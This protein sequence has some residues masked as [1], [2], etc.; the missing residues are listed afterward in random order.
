MS[1][2]RDPLDSLAEEFV[3]R[4]R[5]GERLT[6]S[7]YALDHPEFA[8][9]IRDLFP[10]LV[11]MENLKDPAIAVTERPN[12]MPTAAPERVGDCRI[13]REIGR[14]GMGVVY[15][16]VQE[17][18]ARR[19]AVKVLPRGLI[20]NDKQLHRF[21]R[22][23]RNT[24]K[25]HHSNIVSVFGVGQDE[26]LHYFVMQYIRG[27]GLDKVL[28][29]LHGLLHERKSDHAAEAGQG[30]PPD[31]PHDSV[32]PWAVARR[33]LPPAAAS[34][35]W[36]D[37]RYWRSAANIG[38]QV[39]EALSYAHGRGVIHRD[40]KPGNLLID[41]H[42]VV[43][44]T[45]FGLAKTL[46]ASGSQ[47]GADIV[48]TIRYMAPEQFQG[49]CDPRCDVYSLGVTLYELLSFRPA[50]EDVDLGQLISAKTKTDP[51]LLRTLQPRVP[52]DLEAIV[53]KAMAREPRRR[54]ATAAM[55]VEDLRRFLE[56]KPIRARPIPALERMGKFTRRNPA[57]VS[58]SILLLASVIG[59]FAMIS[60][61]WREAERENQRAEYN[62]ALALDSL[63]ETLNVFATTWMSHPVAPQSDEEGD[64]NEFRMVASLHSARLLQN[65][66]KFY[67]RFAAENATNPRLRHD[68]AK[69]Q[70][71][72]GEIRQ[73]LGQL[74]EAETAL[75]EA[76]AIFEEL[77]RQRPQ[78]ADLAVDVAGAWNNLGGVLREQ[79]R[80]SEAESAHIRAQESLLPF[81][82]GEHRSQTCCFELARTC[83]ELGSVKSRTMQLRPGREYLRQG[84]AILEE[85]I[86]QDGERPEFLVAEARCCVNLYRASLTEPP[87]VTSP[88][89]NTAIVVLDK[90]VASYP[91]VPDYQFELAET[92]T[93]FGVFGRFEESFAEREQRMRRAIQMTGQ[94]SERFPNIPRYRASLAR[95]NHWLA[96]AL[97]RNKREEE[98][99]QLEKRAA[100]LYRELANDYPLVDAYQSFSALASFSYGQ[101]LR[102]RNRLPESRLALEES[103]AR[104]TAYLAK[105]PDDRFRRRTLGDHYASLAETLRRMGESKLAAEAEQKAGHRGWPGAKR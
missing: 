94:L 55:L 27:V 88:L 6:I 104:Q 31:E 63:E 50:Y 68:M 53:A 19:V 103:V 45:D 41:E 77:R 9:A 29:E 35:A 11:A 93:S 89:I 30:S 59:G 101:I 67:D 5:N 86:E 79:A 91:D 71:R 85:L 32:S 102:A 57:L 48:G 105:R 15:E 70:S 40:I 72:V 28:P 43:W 58:L 52:L 22:E 17:S 64:P 74:T 3:S 62:L 26:G 36:P 65:A 56:D 82:R 49:E 46:S 44:V 60:W 99:E 1:I 37:P 20:P 10:A 25:L 95:A 12:S 16:A 14:G 81:T 7:Q 92:L 51:P 73:R 13:I 97:F 23:S 100:D 4:R 47:P 80:F 39:A 33:W 61:K 2:E 75:R 54:Y 84:L 42:G 76:V 78:D 18:L 90:L 69:V 24:A 96:Q 83:A 98:A 66:L 8:A 38:L 21:L 34:R 87:D